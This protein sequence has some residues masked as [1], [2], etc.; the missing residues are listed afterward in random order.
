MPDFRVIPSI[1]QLRQR[2]A[3]RALEARFGHAL[4]VDALRAEADALRARVSGGRAAPATPD[5]AAGEIE[6]ALPR[7]IDMLGAPSLSRAI[8]ATG[9]IIHTNLGRAPLSKAAAERV[10]AIATGYSNLEFD[11]AAGSRGARD[12]HGERLLCRLTGA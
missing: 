7:R 2:A 9:V 4:V 1:E 5:E 8:N 12:V 11:L 3:V 6:R 10:A